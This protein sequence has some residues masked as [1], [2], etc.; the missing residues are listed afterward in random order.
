M[1]KTNNGY[2]FEFEDGYHGWVYGMSAREKKIEIAKHG[3]LIRWE[4]A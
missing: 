2:Y 1:T 3:R 4:R